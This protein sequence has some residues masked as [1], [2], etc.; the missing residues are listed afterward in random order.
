MSEEECG[1]ATVVEG[2]GQYL[3]FF[4]SAL[5]VSGLKYAAYVSYSQNVSGK[6]SYCTLFSFVWMYSIILKSNV[7]DLYN[8]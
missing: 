7:S 3:V 1:L 2:E 4:S 8:Y 6:S 5:S